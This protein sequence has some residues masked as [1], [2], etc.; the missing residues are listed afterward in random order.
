MILFIDNKQNITSSYRPPRYYIFSEILKKQG[1]ECL[2]IFGSWS[3]LLK[4]RIE[5]KTDSVKYINNISYYS[6]KGLRRLLSE[7]FFG[8]Q[9]LFKCSTLLNKAEL[10][11]INDSGVFYNFIFYLLKPIFKYKVVL[12]S[13]DLWPEIFFKS[14]KLKNA[15]YILKS[16]LYKKTD[17]FIAVNNDYL[18]YYK[19]LDSKKIGVIYLGLSKELNKDIE[20]NLFDKKSNR[21]LYLGN[22]GENYLIDEMCNFVLNNSNWCLDCY[23]SGPKENIIERFAIKTSGRIQLYEPCSLDKI[24]QKNIKYTF[25]LALYNSD[26]LV[27]FPTKLIDYWMFSLP[28]I[29]N[30]GEEVKQILLDYPELGLFL[31]HDSEFNIAAI[32]KFVNNYDSSGSTS[33][34]FKYSINDDV[35]KIFT[36]IQDKL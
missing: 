11:V 31:E 23:G 14:P 10:L 27:K 6:H 20:S 4:K 24:K 34:F 33:K 30:V 29:V 35:T 9:V 7:V 18:D 13:N 15:S 5:S 32:S 8:I 16:I 36:E 25:G 12:D 26:S 17:Y 28:V 2:C 22:L 3:H 1:T 19:F 21:L